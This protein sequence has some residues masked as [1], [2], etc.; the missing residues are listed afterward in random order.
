MSRS[1]PQPRAAVTNANRRRLLAYVPAVVG[2][3]ALPDAARAK[4]GCTRDAPYT[5]DTSIPS[6]NQ[7]SRAQVLVLHYTAAP[8]ARSVALLTDSQRPVSAHYLVPDAADGGERFRVFELVP[9]SRRAWHAGVSA[10]RGRSLLN[11]RSIGIEIVNAGFPEDDED[12]PLM[13]RR[14]FP[15]PDA[16]ISVVGR[17]AADIVA[18][19]AIPPQNVVGHSD[20]APGRKFDPGALFPWQALHERYGLGAW[21]EAA[22]VRRHRIDQPFRGDIAELQEKLRSYGYDAPTSGAFNAR[23]QHVV[24]AFQMH[25]RPARYDGVPDIETV[26]ILDALLERY[27]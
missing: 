5:I 4:D 19:H 12:A 14:W 25:F 13:Q 23:T 17:L 3:L 1:R 16:Q 8:L 15:F 2:A 18:R 27:A 10:W 26:A 9:E 7:N 21:P 24:S 20:V 6:P 22:T 11:T